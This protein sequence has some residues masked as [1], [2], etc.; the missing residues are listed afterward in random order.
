MPT[1]GTIL[2]K[3]KSHK[4]HARFWDE[5]C[6]KA[7]EYQALVPDFYQYPPEEASFFE[8]FP[9]VLPACGPGVRLVLPC[10][11]FLARAA[12]HV[13]PPAGD[14]ILWDSRTAHQ[15]RLW[16]HAVSRGGLPDQ[17]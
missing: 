11:A 14:L 13:E 10:C 2:L 6:T 12:S 16:A 7:L 9:T 15:V 3:D 1:A 17:C 5:V 4:A 8:Q